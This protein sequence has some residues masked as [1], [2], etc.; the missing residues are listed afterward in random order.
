[1][2]CKFSANLL[3]RRANIMHLFYVH[4]WEGSFLSFFVLI[5]LIYS[6]LGLNKAGMSFVPY[7]AWK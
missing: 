7:F 5:S 6:R 4:T 2:L 3:L 1:M